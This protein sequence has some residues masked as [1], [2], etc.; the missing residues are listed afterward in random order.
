[1]SD[2]TNA[3]TDVDVVPFGELVLLRHGQTLWSE[4]GQ[5]TGRTNIP[6]T[7]EGGAQAV[8]A[9]VRLRAAYPDGFATVITSDLRRAVQT[10]KLAGFEPSIETPELEEWDYGGAEGRT[11]EEIFQAMGMQWDVWADGPL[12]LSD[13]LSGEHV[14]MFPD[15]SEVTV[16][17]GRGESLEDAATRTR[18][19]IELAMPT[20]QA[21][22]NVLMVA[23]A[24][25]LRILT[26]QWLELEP[27][28]GRKLKLD[29][30][31]YCVLGWYKGD[32][33]IKG[34]NK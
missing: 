31:Q 12:S 5:Y 19:A 21:G 33:V 9:G 13:A 18:R 15:G 4:S 22:G 7:D 20:L 14:E 26:S 28:F 17:N 3:E 27:V 32:H 16:V 25:I 11:R 1:M 10:A 29:T 34:W 6:L 2:A 23:H 8:A 30:A 24:H